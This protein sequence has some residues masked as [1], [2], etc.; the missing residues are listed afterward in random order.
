MPRIIREIHEYYQN[1]IIKGL[2][3][4]V[5]AKVSAGDTLRVIA[6]SAVING[7]RVDLLSDT[8]IPITSFVVD[9]NVKP[10]IDIVTL[11]SNGT[12]I[13]INGIPG[14]IAAPS[15]PAESLLLAQVSL[16]PGW[17]HFVGRG[18]NDEV[19]CI[20]SQHVIDTRFS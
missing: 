16:N 10:R 18:V 8:D 4:Q 3:L 19:L 1:R 13:V 2:H 9:N 15:C 14:E 17:T 12:V 6:G 11:K 7:A 5:V 20:R